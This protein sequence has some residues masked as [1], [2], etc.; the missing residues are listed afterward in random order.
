MGSSSVMNGLSWEVRDRLGDGPEDQ[1]HA[2]A[3]GEEHGQ[4]GEGPQLRDLVVLPEA[5]VLEAADA[6]PH[7]QDEE[8][9]DQQHVVPLEERG[10]Q[11]SASP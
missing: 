1:P 5:D 11:L 10:Q 8:P 9:G 4:P 6:E 7:H 3:R 2:H